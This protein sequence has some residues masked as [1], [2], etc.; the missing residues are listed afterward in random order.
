MDIVIDMDSGPFSSASAATRWGESELDDHSDTEVGPHAELIIVDIW[1]A[2]PAEMKGNI[3]LR[4][5]E[6]LVGGLGSF[7][8]HSRRHAVG[9][10]NPTC[11]AHEVLRRAFRKYGFVVH[12]NDTS[13]GGK[14]V[15]VDD[16][17]A[18]L[19]TKATYTVKDRPSKIFLV[20]GDGASNHERLD[21]YTSVEVCLAA[22]IELELLSWRTKLSHRY[23]GLE[24]DTGLQGTLRITLLDDT[25]VARVVEDLRCPR[26]AVTGSRRSPRSSSERSHN[27][28]GGDSA[29]VSACP[30][31]RSSMLPPERALIVIL[32]VV[33]D[34][35]DAVVAELRRHRRK[36]TH[37][38]WWFFPTKKVGAH[39]H[40]STYITDETVGSLC[41]NGTHMHNLERV[42]EVVWSLNPDNPLSLFP[43]IDRVRIMCSLSMMKRHMTGCPSLERFAWHPLAQC[44]HIPGKRLYMHTVTQ[45]FRVKKPETVKC[46]MKLSVMTM[47]PNTMDWALSGPNTHMLDMHP[48]SATNASFEESLYPNL[49]TPTLYVGWWHVGGIGTAPRMSCQCMRCTSKLRMPLVGSELARKEHLVEKS[50]PSSTGSNHS[51]VVMWLSPKFWRVT[52]EDEAVQSKFVFVP[53][54][55]SHSYNDAI[56]Q[57]VTACLASFRKCPSYISRVVIIT[58][59]PHNILG[60]IETATQGLS[61]SQSPLMV[62]VTDPL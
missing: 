6:D 40:L 42:A 12:S 49:S 9:H 11:S 62:Y 47:K 24:G 37:W 46:S 7:T 48:A 60:K 38:I 16:V 14:E 61:P 21:I 55:R 50:M 36:V 58:E 25:V 17:I 30:V 19:V 20:T 2:V 39:D 26:L 54:T 22:G 5:A 34:R 59:Q 51:C 3:N 57:F 32:D 4:S 18:G 8:A 33:A 10:L 13:S 29:A 28:G 27:S 15:Y 41:S 44:K 1:N 53:D 43:E 52:S 56:L 23:F 31:A 35:V 45:S